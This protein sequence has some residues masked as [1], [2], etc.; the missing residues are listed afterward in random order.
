[1]DPM[2]VN[3]VTFPPWSRQAVHQPCCYR[4]SRADKNDGNRPCSILCGH[5]ARRR[6]DHK[7][8][9]FE[10]GQLLS[11]HPQPVNFVIRSSYFDCYIA[12]FNIAEFTKLSPEDLN[13]SAH[14]SQSEPSNSRCLSRLLRL[15]GRAKR[16]EQSA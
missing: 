1:M 8:V 9:N 15:N 11:Q 16:Q 14:T 6:G 2:V 4:I 7:D 13:P 5:G 12:A 3:P 10:T